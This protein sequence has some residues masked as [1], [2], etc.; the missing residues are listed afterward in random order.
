MNPF[1]IIKT[2]RRRRRLQSAV[3]NAFAGGQCRIVVGASG[4]IPDG[5][6]GTDIDQLNLLSEQD[7]LRYFR[8]GSVDSILAEHVW[9]HL[10]P[11]QGL[12]AATLCARFLKPGGYLRAAVPDGGHTDSQYIDYVKPGGSGAGADD[13]KVLYTQE[14]FATMFRSAG[15]GD[16]DTLEY[17]DNDGQFQA[18]QWSEAEGMIH[19]SIRFDKRNQDGQPRYTSLIVDAKKMAA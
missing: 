16:V 12:Q 7:W 1:K 19:R 10:T 9:E 11:E 14:S 8:P 4:V 17:F 2:L 6:I 18:S 13:H 3:N 15:F 5:W